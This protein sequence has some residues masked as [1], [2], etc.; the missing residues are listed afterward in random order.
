MKKE[1]LHI[2]V[3]VSKEEQVLKG[4][5]VKAQIKYGETA[6]LRLGYKPIVH[7][8]LGKSASRN[9]LKNRPV[10]ANIIKQIKS[11]EVTKLFTF[12]LTR[13]SRDS[14]VMAFLTE[15]FKSKKIALHTQAIGDYN[16]AIDSDKLIFGLMGQV[17][18][19]DAHMRIKRMQLGIIQ[20]NRNGK[21]MGG[22]VPYGYDKDV[23]GF[24]VINKP[25][26]NAIQLMVDMYLKNDLGCDTI[27]IKLEEMNIPTK[28]NS[29]ENTG[30]VLHE[31]K[32]NRFNSK[33]ITINKWNAGTIRAIFKNTLIKGVRQ[34]K[35]DEEIETVNCPAIIDEDTWNE[36]QEK[37]KLN[38]GTKKRK[39]KYSYLLKGLLQCGH[40]GQA[41]HGRIKPSRSEKMYRC[42]CK[43]NGKKESC[44]G[45]DR[46]VHID[47]L[48]NA[49]WNSLTCS[50]LFKEHI[51]E[52]NIYLNSYGDE[53]GFEENVKRLNK[54]LESHKMNYESLKNQEEK[55]LE[56]FLEEQI[57]KSVLDKK[58]EQISNGLIQVKTDMGKTKFE[59]LE[60]EKTNP[61]VQ[62]SEHINSLENLYSIMKTLKELNPNLDKNHF[63]IRRIIDKFIEKIVIVYDEYF[64]KHVAL[65]YF[66]GSSDEHLIINVPIKGVLTTAL[67]RGSFISRQIEKCKT[68]INMKSWET[69]F[70]FVLNNP[71]PF[72]IVPRMLHW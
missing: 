58:I 64:N 31:G 3:R 20:A 15:L 60:L 30:Y 42:H 2:Y 32:Q 27:A 57:S 14:Q 12:D 22:N 37:R 65:I 18:Q 38:Y 13:L 50:K 63:E 9:N 56:L 70:F 4:L 43:R 69:S 25:E 24:L 71:P 40:C 16:F 8:E 44:R 62:K 1:E 34:F 7:T 66:R 72:M 11:G 52:V 41:L 23:N 35:A 59:L 21:Y 19:H 29:K 45:W 61:T 51:D 47:R 54:L 5:S 48:N 33:S 46:N 36:I 26:S 28:N 68:T 6:A 17:S 39:P 53:I 10:L 55:C 49:V 67:D